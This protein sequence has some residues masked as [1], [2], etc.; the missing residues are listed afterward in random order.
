MTA[1]VLESATDLTAEWLTDALPL[2]DGTKATSFTSTAVGTGQMADT[3]RLAVEY[4]PAGAGPASVVA[5]FASS[6]PN[7]RAASKLVRCYEIEVSI[8]NE[9]APVPGVPEHYFAAWDR[10][11]DFFTLLL[12]DVAPC[13]QGNDI[14]GCDER[15]AAEAMKRLAAIHAFAWDSP[16]HA[17]REWLNRASPENT[18]NVVAIIAM[19][20]PSFFERFA[21][22]LDPEHQALVER[23]IP[24]V[25]R[26]VE[27]YDGPR[28]LA[29]G[30]YRLDNMLFPEGSPTPMI[31]DWQTAAWGPPAA[32]V[33]LFLGGSLTTEARRE[34]W[35]NLLDVYHQALVAEG[36]TSYS[37]E[38]LE[39]DVRLSSFG[40]AVMAVMSAILVVQTERG[41]EMFAELF[42]RHAQHAIDIDGEALLAGLPG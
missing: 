38:Q 35:G 34:H 4:E 37:R 19:T 10:E 1:P 31:V 23:V 18:A 25:P 7:S 30:D 9:L 42:R 28:T 5:K 8:Y 11:A 32:D 24:Q 20:A 17:A 12:A 15:V 13:T 21:K 33:A 14:E 16:E 2:P 41:D 26:I 6:D 36:I 27:A 40:G 39:H 29:H 22:H 3:Y